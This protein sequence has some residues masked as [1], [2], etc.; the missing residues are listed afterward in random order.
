[1]D[2]MGLQPVEWTTASLLS[3]VVLM[4]LFGWL[5]PRSTL[6][7]AML[8]RDKWRQ[9]ALDLQDTNRLHAEAAKENTEPSKTVAKLLAAAQDRIGV[10][11]DTTEDT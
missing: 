4:I 7:S 3:L 10:E 11:S 2:W 6:K 5:T 8:D 9:V 1:M